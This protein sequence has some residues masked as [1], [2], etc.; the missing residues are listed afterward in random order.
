ML[1]VMSNL[2]LRADKVEEEDE[3]VAT[4]AVDYKVLL[5]LLNDSNLANRYKF[6]LW[7]TYSCSDDNYSTLDQQYY[8]DNIHKQ[9]SMENTHRHTHTHIHTHIHTRIVRLYLK[10]FKIF[11]ILCFVSNTGYATR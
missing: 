11:A 10:A 4:M 9:D 3:E 2:L 8:L 6:K 5:W 7:Q 1:T